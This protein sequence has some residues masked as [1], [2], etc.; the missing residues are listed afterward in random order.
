MTMVQAH[1]EEEHVNKWWK[2]TA[3]C[4]SDTQTT[5]LWEV[6]IIEL[7]WQRYAVCSH[8]NHERFCVCCVKTV[9]TTSLKKYVIC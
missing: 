9:P 1:G 4:C 3:V 5:R 7:R 2:R 8:L 6:W